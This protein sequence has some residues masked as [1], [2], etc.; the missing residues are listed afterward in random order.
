[1]MQEQTMVQQNSFDPAF[2]IT[3]SGRVGST[4]QQNAAAAF[5]AKKHQKCGAAS[6]NSLAI[7]RARHND[8]SETEKVGKQ[9]TFCNFKIK[10]RRDFCM[11]LH[12]KCLPL[13]VFTLMKMDKM[14]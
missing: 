13:M 3:H 8:D 10:N 7:G 4:I 6:S 5:F 2:V 14:N 11:S 9:G 12:Q 1:M